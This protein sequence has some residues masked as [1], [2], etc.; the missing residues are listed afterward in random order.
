[1]PPLLPLRLRSVAE[2]CGG[3]RAPRPTHNDTHTD[4]ISFR[5]LILSF[6]PCII[7]TAQLSPSGKVAPQGRMRDRFA[8]A[9]P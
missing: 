7:T 6:H 3:V 2:A 9:D 5:H 8:I 1:M 4:V